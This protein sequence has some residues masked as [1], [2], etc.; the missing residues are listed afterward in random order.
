MVRHAISTKDLNAPAFILELL[1][2]TPWNSSERDGVVVVGWPLRYTDSNGDSRSMMVY[3]QG[4]P[5]A[6]YR[7][8]GAEY[9]I[10]PGTSLRFA[11]NVDDGFITQFYGAKSVIDT[12]ANRTFADL[13]AMVKGKNTTPRQWQG[14]TARN[15]AVTERFV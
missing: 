11:E 2:D 3:F 10:A 7:L 5:E 12:T 8:N 15:S 6:G 4:S 9:A 13:K 1:A 14:P